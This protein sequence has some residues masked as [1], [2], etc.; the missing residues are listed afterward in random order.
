MLFAAR[1]A[2]ALHRLFDVLPVFAGD[3][4]IRRRFTL[5]P[6]SEFGRDAREAVERFGGLCVPWEVALAETHDLV[7]A[8]SPK[9]GLGQL[10][11][12]KV[13]L[14]HGA[15]FSKAL[16]WEGTAGQASGF[17]PAFL[18]GEDGEPVAALHALAHPD[19]AAR[20]TRAV[21]A[22]AGRVAVVGDPTLER[23][24]A[25]AGQRSR[26]RAALAT[27][28]RRLVVLTSTWGPESLLGRHPGLPGRL[29]RALPCDA[30]QLALIAHPNTHSRLGAREF[31]ERLAPALD[32][33][34]VQA[35]TYEEWGA[36]LVAA[37]AVLTD[38]GSTALYAA[39][40]GTP[41]VAACDG[42]NEL[43]PGSPMAEVLYRIPMLGDPGNPGD[44][45]DL[46]KILDAYASSGVDVRRLASPA[47]AGQ[48]RVLERLRHELY[49]L[50][51]LVP[52]GGAGAVDARPLPAPVSTGRDI[53]A[54]AV[55]IEQ[56]GGVVHIERTHAG[57]RDGVHHLAA[58]VDR[59]TTRQSQSA[60]LLFRRAATAPEDRYGEEWTVRGWI[61][62]TLEEYGARRTAAVVLGPG[63]CAVRRHG[64]P[65]WEVRV[66]PCREDGRVFRTDPAAVLSAVHA[67]LGS[68]S[69]HR[70]IRCVVAGRSYEADLS[71]AGDDMAD[72][73]C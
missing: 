10:R 35:R 59:A 24:L 54:F 65:L 37:D 4:R 63:H 17:D 66:A 22:V 41:L 55:R 6:G 44:T 73:V 30:Y 5:V 39:A 9:G 11:G 56:H 31:T 72:R 33:G 12:P 52:P 36:L 16:P 40:L 64:G 42:G 48:G 47:F 23:M 29:A 53:A 34:M 61:D 62:R 49:G 7:V 58:E 45:S 15:G 18:V 60:G 27:G 50:L 2:G 1:S 46:G 71:P 8:A 26:Y 43:I 69:T 38:H 20:L 19:Q 14:P 3:S 70:R 13:L 21:P 28:G 25:S 57:G 51:G 32:A 68:G 67:L